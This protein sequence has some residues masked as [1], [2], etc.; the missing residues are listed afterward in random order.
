[1]NN[2]FACTHNEPYSS[3]IFLADMRWSL[4]VLEIYIMVLAR[5]VA[6]MQLRSREIFMQG[7]LPHPIASSRYRTLIIFSV[8]HI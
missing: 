1:M 4:V 6:C 2:N 7:S 8:V 3:S 5:I